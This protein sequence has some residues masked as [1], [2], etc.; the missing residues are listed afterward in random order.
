MA[1][2]G[3]VLNIVKG[4]VAARI[5][6]SFD[7]IISNEL[8]GIV[9]NHK[10]EAN[11]KHTYCITY[12]TAAWMVVLASIFQ[13]TVFAFA[14][15]SWIQK[16]HTTHLK[17]IRTDRTMF[18]AQKRLNM[19]SSFAELEEVS[20]RM[21]VFVDLEYDDLEGTSQELNH[22]R[23]RNEI[24]RSPVESSPLATQS[25]T[26]SPPTK[27]VWIARL[28]LLLSAALYGTNFT[29]VKS[30][31]ELLSVGVSSTLRFGFAAIC[32]LPWLVAPIDDQLKT[33]T[34]EKFDKCKGEITKWEEPTR[35]AAGLAGMEIGVYNSIGYITQAVGLKT[36]PANKVRYF[37]I[38]ILLFQ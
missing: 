5:A 12:P 28:L 30:L 27:E 10:T 4:F 2:R 3:D 17:G 31:D 19:I 25:M 15:T 36:I 37:A 16:A 34:K 13:A 23:V 9:I 21:P 38:E 1:G 26:E 14:P 7:T 35:L 29:V 20:R 22:D 32:M 18:L 8:K 33:I 24:D 6:P 11:M